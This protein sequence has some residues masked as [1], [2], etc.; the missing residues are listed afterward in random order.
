MSNTI[1]TMGIDV[2]GSYIKVVIMEYNDATGDHKIIDK[3]TE[4]IRRRNPKHVVTELHRLY[5]REEQPQL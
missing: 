5:T 4:K 3:K 1:Y 2:G